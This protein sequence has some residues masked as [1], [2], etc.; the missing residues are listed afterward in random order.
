VGEELIVVIMMGLIIMSALAVIWM[1]M[2][3]R[4]QIR[5][6]EH[7]ERLAMIE[8]GLV[9]PPEVDPAGFERGLGKRL[10][11]EGTVRFR[12]AGIMMIGL[13]AALAVL[14]T[15][16][17]GEAA[18]G[19]GIG[20]AFAA[21]GAAFLANAAMLGRSQQYVSRP[22]PPPLTSQRREEPKAEDR[23]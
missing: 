12:S 20:L 4:R 18:V 1:S 17:A 7:R 22:T 11:T 8:R 6:M 19:F 23:L 13:G 16:T 5:E 15:F 2:N 14:V 3:S 10:E 21:L 9:P